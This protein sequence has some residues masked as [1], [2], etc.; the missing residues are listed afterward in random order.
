[1]GR[2][3]QTTLDV[4]VMLVCLRHLLGDDIGVV[5]MPRLISGGSRVGTAVRVLFSP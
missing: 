5:H 2:L 1:M 3:R 4:Y